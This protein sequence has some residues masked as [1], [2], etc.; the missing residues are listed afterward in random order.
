MKY[1]EAC[2]DAEERSRTTDGESYIPSYQ[3]KAIK[4][5]VK[6]KDEE[7]GPIFATH[8]LN[9]P[10]RQPVDDRLTPPP[11][12]T[13]SASNRPPDSSPLRPISAAIEELE[14]LEDQVDELAAD[15]AP[16]ETPRRDPSESMRKWWK[17]PP[18]PT[19]NEKEERFRQHWA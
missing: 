16:D 1:E 9:R 6:V 14:D 15:S 13:S 2:G 4:R 8:K 3:A 12:A 19:P 7:A 11:G 17:L 10:G 5:E 18:T